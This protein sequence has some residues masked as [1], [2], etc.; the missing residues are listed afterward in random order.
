MHICSF[1]DILGGSLVSSAASGQML[2]R[3]HDTLKVILELQEQDRFR[4]IDSHGLVRIDRFV[5]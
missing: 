2:G 1:L 4:Y 5:C 3:S